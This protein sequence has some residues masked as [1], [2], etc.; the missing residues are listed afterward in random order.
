VVRPVRPRVHGLEGKTREDFEVVVSRFKEDVSWVEPMWGGHA[1][2]YDRS[3]EPGPEAPGPGHGHGHVPLPHLALLSVGREPGA[4]LYHIVNR[5]DDLAE[6]TLFLHGN[7]FEHRTL[8]WDGYVLSPE[9]FVTRYN[10][11]R[12]M[13]EPYVFGPGNT[14]DQK[15]H[16]ILVPDK[17]AWCKEVIERVPAVEHAHNWGG[18]FAV[19]KRLILR[20]GRAYWQRLLEVALSESL[21]LA[22][23]KRY[24]RYEIGIM[25]EFTWPLIMA[26]RRE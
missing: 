15:R 16:E 3:E 8:P 18:Q 2:I 13:D 23:R 1:T 4:Y 11:R 24:T 20:C 10:D 19:D 26:G 22:T 17:Y 25:F 9:P 6:R 7:P 14:V 12:K 5:W 21:V